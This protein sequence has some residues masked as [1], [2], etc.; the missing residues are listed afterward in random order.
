MM[1]M[2]MILTSLNLN[3]TQR[4][5]FGGRNCCLKNRNSMRL[6]TLLKATLLGSR[7]PGSKTEAESRSNH[8][9]VSHSVGLDGNMRGTLRDRWAEVEVGGP[10]RSLIL[11]TPLSFQVKR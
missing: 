2:I 7:E 8:S 4:G 11:T 9:V 1:M 5:R 10:V 3:K 6:N